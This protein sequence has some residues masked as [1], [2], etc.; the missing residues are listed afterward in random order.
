MV[1]ELRDRGLVTGEG[2]PEETPAGRA[3]TDRVVAAR[4]ELLAELVADGGGAERSPEVDELLRRLSRELV[5][6]EP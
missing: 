4:R 2:A 6:E 1:G 3:V 5:G